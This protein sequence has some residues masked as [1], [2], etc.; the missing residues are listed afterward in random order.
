MNDDLTLR[1][2]AYLDGDL[3]ADDR[4]LVEADALALA[5]VERLRYVRV[6]LADAGQ[7]S[8]AVREELLANAMGAWDRLSETERQGRDTRDAHAITTPTSL[9][10][11]R[12]TG[13]SRWM[14][15]AAAALV[16]VLAG[17][18]AVR[19]TTTGTVDS[20]ASSTSSAT[21][22]ADAPTAA[23]LSARD[24]TGAL[25]PSVGGSENSTRSKLD[26][27]INTPAPPADGGLEQLTTRDDLAIFAADAVDVPSVP[28]GPTAT[29][30]AIDNR[31]ADA[32]AAVP[33]AQ[34]PLCLGA[35]YV[36]GP[37]LYGNTEVVVGVD[38]SRN[39]AL[40]YVAA[41]CREVAR[42]PLP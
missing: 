35:D 37:A 7:L 18:M 23:A 15:G 5:E 29:S 16:V 21:L 40:A 10:S 1:A 8:I 9:S 17:G 4:A 42:A 3:T 24:E 27:G 22:P 26:T 14:L 41:N 6:L 20:T 33:G 31:L 13:S 12:R 36:V 2:S 11:R 39:L 28:D 32:P 30:G 19:F 25:D 38:T 34:W